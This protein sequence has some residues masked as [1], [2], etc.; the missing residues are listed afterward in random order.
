MN[1]K[2]RVWDKEGGYFY[3]PD[4][5][6]QPHYVLSLNGEFLNFQ[7]GVG[8]KEVV[9]QQWTGL[10]DEN[11]IDVYEGDIVKCFF[12]TRQDKVNLGVI[13]FCPKYGNM[14]IKIIYAGVHVNAL[15]IPK[16]FFNFV[17][18]DGAFNVEVIS[19]IF[20]D[21]ELLS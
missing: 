16:P 9:V 3:M 14:G 21:Q 18:N 12:N 11:G 13:E 19:N 7:N 20:Q 4:K 8:G 5:G 15:E 1:K 2:F 10:Q 17:K 6:Y